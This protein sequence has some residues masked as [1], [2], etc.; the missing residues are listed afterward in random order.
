MTPL[1][2][3]DAAWLALGIGVLTYDLMARDGEQF[4]DATDRYTLLHPWITR[5]VI[6][7]TVVHLT[8]LIPPYLDAFRLPGAIRGQVREKREEVIRDNPRSCLL[9]EGS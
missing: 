2:P 6:A 8:R 7:A 3:G 5:L 4:S 9:V 1:R